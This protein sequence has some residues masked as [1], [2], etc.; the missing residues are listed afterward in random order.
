MILLFS[1]GRGNRSVIRAVKEHFQEDIAVV[2]NAYDDGKSSGEVR[3]AFDMFG[4]SDLRKV[5]LD[6]A[7]L[8]TW[9]NHI[10]GRIDNSV[11]SPLDYLTDFAHNLDTSNE[12]QHLV[13]MALLQFVHEEIRRRNAGK[14]PIKFDDFSVSNAIYAGLFLLTGRDTVQTVRLFGHIV[15]SSVRVYPNTLTS[16]VYLAARTVDDRILRSEAEIVG[17][18]LNEP[19]SHVFSLHRPFDEVFDYEQFMTLS[20]QEQISRLSSMHFDPYLWVE[21]QRLIRRASM[22]I[23]CPGTQHSSLLPTYRTKGL[24]DE[25]AR[26]DCP[27]ILITNI[28]ADYEIPRFTAAD[29]FSLATRAL[30]SSCETHEKYF[31]THVFVNSPPNL[32]EVP[33]MYVRPGNITSIVP[34]NTQI[35]YSN[36]EGNNAGTH[37]TDQ[38]G[39]HFAQCRDDSDRRRIEKF[40]QGRR[41]TARVN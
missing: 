8:I 21:I 1:G 27:K 7:S 33:Q 29:I 15:N 23:M 9:A 11:D 26:A 39:R 40:I 31:F 35:I 32:A 3:R 4:P 10:D 16:H 37:S 24:G 36:F 20:A 6:Q 2:V 5:Q 38:L 12:R 25:L 28:G 18:R 41:Q 22:I 17:S 13:Q 14:T 30:R 34:D 19:I